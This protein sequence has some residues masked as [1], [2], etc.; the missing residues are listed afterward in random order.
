[1]FYVTGNRSLLSPMCLLLIWWCG[2]YS[3]TSQ[4]LVATSSSLFVYEVASW[5]V[6]GLYGDVYMQLWLLVNTIRA[7]SVDD[8]ATRP[9]FPCLARVFLEGSGSPSWTPGALLGFL[10]PFSVFWSLGRQ[11]PDTPGTIHKYIDFL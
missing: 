10:E 6:H 2:H 1:M 11:F 4:C 5:F 3:R 9:P 8:C 7:S